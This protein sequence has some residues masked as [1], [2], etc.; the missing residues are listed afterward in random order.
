MK[1]IITIAIM[2]MVTGGALETVMP[3]ATH[4]PVVSSD[5]RA[6]DPQLRDMVFW[7]NSWEVRSSVPSNNDGVDGRHFLYKSG[8]T[9]RA[10]FYANSE[11]RYV[12]FTDSG[13]STYLLTSAFDDSLQ[14]YDGVTTNIGTTIEV[15]TTFM[16]TLSALDDSLSKYSKI[17]Y[18]GNEILGS[19]QFQ[20]ADSLLFK[21]NTYLSFLMSSGGSGEGDETVEVMPDT[22]NDIATIRYV[23]DAV[24]GGSG[25]GASSDG[26][27]LWNNAGN[28]DGFGNWNNPQRIFNIPDGG[29]YS[30]GGTV[31]L[32]ADSSNENLYVGP[33]VNRLTSTDNIVISTLDALNGNAMANGTGVGQNYVIGNCAYFGANATKT[34]RNILIGPLV[35]YHAA[36]TTTGDVEKNVILSGASYFADDATGAVEENTVV[37]DGGLSYSSRY[38]SVVK[39]NS[40]IGFNAGYNFAQNTT[41]QVSYNTLVGTLSGYRAFQNVATGHIFSNTLIGDQSGAYW[42]QN[43]VGSRYGIGV[44]AYSLYSAVA[45]RPTAIGGYAMQNYVDGSYVTAIGYES[46]VGAE[47]DYSIYIGNESGEGL[48]GDYKLYIG[49]N[50]DTYGHIITGDM[51]NDS[52]SANGELRVRDGIGVGVAQVAEAGKIQW[53]G[54]NFQ[55]H[56]GSN[57]LNLD[58]DGPA[59]YGYQNDAAGGT[60]YS[61]ATF[62]TLLWNYGYGV[63]IA[64]LQASVPSKLT[65]TVVADTNEVATQDTLRTNYL[66][67][68]SVD[69]S[70]LN[71]GITKTKITTENLRV[72]S[73]NVEATG[74]IDSYLIEGAD[75]TNTTIGFRMTNKLDGGLFSHTLLY[76]N[77]GTKSGYFG[78]YSSGSLVAALQSRTVVSNENGEGVGIIFPTGKSIGFFES[79]VQKHTMWD[80]STDFNGHVIAD[81]FQVDDKT[82]WAFKVM[83]SVKD[84]LTITHTADNTDTLTFHL[85]YG[86]DPAYVLAEDTI[87]VAVDT[88][89]MATVAALE[90]S[91]LDITVAEWYI[92]ADSTISHIVAD[93]YYAIDFTAGTQLNVTETNDSTLTIVR[94][95]YYHINYS[96]S[97]TSGTNNTILHASLFVDDVEDTQT[98][99]QRKIGTGG[100]TGNFGGTGIVWLDSGDTVKLKLK[101]DNVSTST[102]NHANFNI[103]RIR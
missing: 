68:V 45:D 55:G 60:Y 67:R 86:L 33:I 5:A 83:R 14:N 84:A 36:E 1:K 73:S 89:E 77:A 49:S 7:I 74:A 29:G 12:D 21:N 102:I 97:S 96:I 39:R 93:K 100:D 17:V 58:Y 82:Q 52:L 9:V 63:D 42:N 76:A 101:A 59:Y 90:D 4:R 94:D 6:L 47:G 13:T 99:A 65:I 30:L 81:S 48:S 79:T 75:S 43:S 80:D 56:D 8:D 69:D 40:S 95:G 18:F 54:S 19:P 3:Q 78:T 34:Y 10:Y 57:W 15:D 37:G 91:L 23:D 98:E 85:G 32:T 2:I 88:S 103:I 35:A 71:Y 92:G 64:S 61:S 11:W 38:G 50:T 72:Y 46:A 53:D 44:G 26:E 62:D 25:V 66:E 27:V 22:L 70:L 41:G 16:A 28:V 87:G 24:A 51:K 31:Y 20:P